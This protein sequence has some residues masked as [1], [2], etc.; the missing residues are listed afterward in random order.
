MKSALKSLSFSDLRHFAITV[1]MFLSVIHVEAQSELNVWVQDADTKQGVAFANVFLKNLNTGVATDLQG[2]ATLIIP[3]NAG[4]TDTLM[5]SFIGYI[6]QKV[7][8]QP[9]KDLE[10]QVLLESNLMPLPEIEVRA[11]VKQLNGL[12][13]V[14]EALSKIGENYP[15]QPTG[16]EGLYREILMENDQAV[17]L[18]EALVWI[19]YAT[20]PQKSYSRKSWKS[21]WN[22]QFYDTWLPFRQYRK[23]LLVGHPQFFKYY[24]APEDQ[25]FVLSSR[26]SL[27]LISEELEPELWSGPFGLLAADKVKYGADFLDT[28]LLEDY[29]YQRGAAV[30]VNDRVCIAVHFKPK[31]VAKKV[32]QMWQDKIGFPLFSGTLYISADEMAIIKLEC[33]FV[34]SNETKI[35]Q[36]S[37]P[38]QIYPERVKVEVDYFKGGKWLPGKISI[39]QYISGNSSDKW[40]FEHNYLIK[41]EIFLRHQPSKTGTFLKDAIPFKD[42]HRANMRDLPAPYLKDFWKDFLQRNNYPDLSLEVREALEKNTP[43]E[44]Q[45]SLMEKRY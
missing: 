15:D 21:Y 20:Y 45:F 22:E 42:I 25:V 30:I 11:E 26:K 6:P 5:V 24:A 14:K 36:V 18:N 27:N 41:R 13:L 17:W 8:F 1:W 34:S 3:P 12:E 4:E 38:W 16:M 35:Y 44:E 28:K 40:Q 7:P 10:L 39:E 2:K 9:R 37:D 19:D 32:H 33:Q 43:L 31:A 29:H 23:S